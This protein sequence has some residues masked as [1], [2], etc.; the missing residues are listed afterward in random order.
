[1]ASKK[2]RVAIIGVGNCASSLVQ[3]VQFYKNAKQDES[4][5]GI[6]HTQ[7]GEYHVRDIEFTLAI[8]VNA[9]KVGKDLS[10]AIFAEPNNTYKFADVPHLGVPVVLL[11]RRFMS[12]LVNMGSL[13]LA[14]LGGMLALAIVG[15]PISM[16][17]FIGVLMLFGI[18]AKNSILLIDFAIE[19]MERGVPKFQAIMEAGHKRAQPIVMT[20]VA[21]TAGMIPTALSLGGDGQWRAPMGTVVIGGLIV[22]TLLTLLIVPA[23]FSLADGL[24]KRAVG[25][26]NG[27][28]KGAAAQLACAGR[29]VDRLGHGL[30]IHQ[31]HGQHHGHASGRGSRLEHGRLRGSQ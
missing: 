11:Y 28:H 30:F 7:L 31:H 29:G 19:E 13:L 16:P 1:M 9:T 5:P 18:V 27:L 2:V 26:V 6:M 20:T 8:D 23:G 10:E 4:I 17:V 14:P 3:G 12:P 22:S 24:E 15:Q 25:E 21:M